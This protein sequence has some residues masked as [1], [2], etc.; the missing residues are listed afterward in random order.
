M[1][2]NMHI[3]IFCA[4]NTKLNYLSSWTESSSD[5]LMVDNNADVYIIGTVLGGRGEIARLPAQAWGQTDP[6][7]IDSGS[8]FSMT[9]HHHDPAGNINN[10]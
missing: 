8:F 2:N 5:T 4:Y 6:I 10:S 3:H 9:S 1:Y 7:Y